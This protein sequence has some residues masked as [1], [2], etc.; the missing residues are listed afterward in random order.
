MGRGKRP[1]SDEEK[2]EEEPTKYGEGDYWDDRYGGWAPD[3]YDWLFE[4]ADVAAPIEALIS[5]EDRVLLPGCGNAP[6]S[7]HMYDAGFTNQFNFDTSAIVIQQCKERNTTREGMQ[8]EVLDACDLPLKNESFEA[9][10][11]KS[12]ID[13]L[14]CCTGSA[15]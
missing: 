10:V 3:P 4:W 13:T 12:L 5:K 7:P 6:F 11:D 15:E 8:W 14:R 9:I 1:M 2:E